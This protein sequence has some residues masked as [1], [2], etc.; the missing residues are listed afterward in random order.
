M[1]KVSEM[2][3]KFRMESLRESGRIS[4]REKRPRILERIDKAPVSLLIVI[5]I[6][7]L[8]IAATGDYLTGLDALFFPAY[9]LPIIFATWAIGVESGYL[10]AFLSL[11]LW[12]KAEIL[13]G[14]AY[15]NA[16]IYFANFL[17]MSFAFGLIAVGCG[18]I[19]RDMEF[20]RRL[21]SHDTM[22]GLHNSVS[23]RHILVHEVDRQRRHPRPVSLAFIDLDNFK[24]V[25]HRFGHTRGDNLLRG[26]AGILQ[27]NIR[28]TDTAGR[29]GGDQFALILPET[30][31]AGALIVLKKIHAAISEMDL[32][33]RGGA[34]PSTG[35]ITFLSAPELGEQHM[36]SLADDL[37]YE[38]KRGGKNRIVSRVHG[39]DRDTPAVA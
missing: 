32:S 30:D 39:G 12:Q 15:E 29:V 4:Y 21:S 3:G 8:L 24:S 10:T 23:F 9:F 22:T 11:V 5:T 27:K 6:A 37:M 26:I 25:N 20:F 17:S 36:L 35:I 28:R 14:R 2:D 33:L 13:G 16:A 18:K 31:E 19:K 34:T 1:G 38:A 7:L